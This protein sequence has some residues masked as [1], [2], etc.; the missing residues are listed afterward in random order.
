MGDGHQGHRYGGAVAAL[1]AVVG[2]AQTVVVQV[3]F[4]VGPA[5]DATD[6]AFH[7]RRGG[8][9]IPFHGDDLGGAQFQHCL[10]ERLGVHIDAEPRFLTQ[11][12]DHSIPGVV[13]PV[14]PGHGLNGQAVVV[15][16]SWAV[17]VM[18]A[19]HLEWITE[20]GDFRA[21]LADLGCAQLADQITG[22]SAGYLAAV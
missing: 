16:H 17:G 22:Q 9:V 10:E 18:G 13:E 8:A 1:G 5:V 2:V 4:H 6:A 15:G 3:C 12:D 14:A 21:H 11:E 20:L 7:V 19:G